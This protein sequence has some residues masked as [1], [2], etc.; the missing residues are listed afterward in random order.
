M[1]TNPLFNAAAALAYIGLVVL[2]ISN[3]ERLAGTPETIL[4]PM[5]ML[6]LFVLSAATMGYIFLYHPLLMVLAGEHKKGAT[7][8]LHTLGIFAG[9]VA[10]LLVLMI[11]VSAFF[12]VG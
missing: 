7:L 11:A 12:L 6:S 4:I 2:G 1:T 3:A 8:F 10:V 5:A 9:I